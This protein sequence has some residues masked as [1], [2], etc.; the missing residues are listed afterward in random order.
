MKMGMEGEVKN[1][2][3]GVRNG[4]VDLHSDLWAHG[5]GQGSGWRGLGRSRVESEWGHPS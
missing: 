1:E 2:E 3:G 5:P 4:G